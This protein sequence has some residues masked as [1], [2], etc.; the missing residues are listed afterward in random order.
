MSKTNFMLSDDWKDLVVN[1]PDETAGQLMKT[2]FLYH[3]GEEIQIDDPV[4]NAV[5]VMVKE[6][7]D[8][9]ERKYAETCKKRSEAAKTS[10]SQQMQANANSSKQMQANANSSQ[11]QAPDNDNDIKEKD[12][13]KDTSKKKAFIKPTLEEVMSYCLE[14]QNGIDAERFI[15]YYESNGWKVG[16][17]PMRDWRACVRSWEKNAKENKP[18]TKQVAQNRFINFDQRQYDFAALERA[19]MESQRV[20]DG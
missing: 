14:R 15:D 2:I 3:A 12:V 4:L 8:E 19:K 10:R 7:I 17:N 1:L 16:K 20:R 5:F 6:Y 18:Q 13:S 9:N 11:Q